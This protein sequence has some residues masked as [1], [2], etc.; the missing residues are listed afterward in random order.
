MYNSVLKIEALALAI[1]V[2]IGVV[3][4][5]PNSNLSP[6]KTAEAPRAGR[7]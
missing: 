4:Y 2:G 3:L 5:V 6:L 1:L 7:A